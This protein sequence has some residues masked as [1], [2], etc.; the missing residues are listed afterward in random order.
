MKIR[1]ADDMFSKNSPKP[2]EGKSR[3][4]TNKTKAVEVARFASSSQ[5]VRS[6][7][8]EFDS[9]KLRNDNDGGRRKESK[10]DSFRSS[11]RSTN[12]N[13]DLVGQARK[14]YEKKL[15]ERQK[16]PLMYQELC[17]RTP[18]A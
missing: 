7:T 15:K 14:G 9:M 13:K 11:G 3:K 12:D 4:R 17:F 6:V 18:A 10:S 5:S 1:Q 2:R 8:F 16:K